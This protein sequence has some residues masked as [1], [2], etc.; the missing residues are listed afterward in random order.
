MQLMLEKNPT[1]VRLELNRQCGSLCWWYVSEHFYMLRN[2]CAF[3]TWCQEW[4]YK[5]VQTHLV[6]P[7]GGGRGCRM[8]T[9]ISRSMKTLTGVLSGCSKSAAPHFPLD[10]NR[11]SHC[12]L[13]INLFVP[14]ICKN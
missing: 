7:Q 13:R 10:S 11:E 4:H 14:Y 6:L 8:L 3:T 9:F 12:N 2:S 5:L 1:L